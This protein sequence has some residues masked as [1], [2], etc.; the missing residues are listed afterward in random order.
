MRREN[1]IQKQIKK[2][3]KQITAEKRERKQKEI[4][5]EK[6]RLAQQKKKQKTQKKKPRRI[7]RKKY[8]PRNVVKRK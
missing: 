4:K 5:G 8:D 7:N 3:W 2:E 1:R 6:S